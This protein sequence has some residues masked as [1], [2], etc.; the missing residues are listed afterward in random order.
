[1]LNPFEPA[2]GGICITYSTV[3]LKATDERLFPFS[4]HRSRRIHKKLVK[5]FGGE[6]RKVPAIFQTPQGLIA[7]P[8]L[9]AEIERQFAPSH[10]GLN[11]TQ[12]DD[13]EHHVRNLRESANMLRRYKA[14]GFEA[15]D[16][17][18]IADMLERD[19]ASHTEAAELKTRVEAAHAAVN[20]LCRVLG[21][22]GMTLAQQEC[23]GEPLPREAV[24]LSFMGSGASDNVTVGELEDAMELARQALGTPA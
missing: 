18:A 16:M 2:F 7:H 24:I 12:E 3:A 11:M 4:K 15:S 14:S 23:I 17:E 1:M 22:V 19:A 9:R 21:P 20:A 8:A 5:R 10:K 13:R 6:F